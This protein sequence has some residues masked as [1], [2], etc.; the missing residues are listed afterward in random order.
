LSITQGVVAQRAELIPLRF[1]WFGPTV[2]CFAISPMRW[3]GLLIAN[4]EL[5][6]ATGL[7][8]H[9]YRASADV[10]RSYGSYRLLT[11]PDDAS[12]ADV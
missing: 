3:E 8:A 12:S 5:E 2:H 7:L 9:R 4:L 11:G 6:A 1:V 10:A